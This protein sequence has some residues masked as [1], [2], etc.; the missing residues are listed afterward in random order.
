MFT[1]SVVTCIV[2]G[3]LVSVI[4]PGS[5]LLHAAH[6]QKVPVRK[7]AQ[8]PR[9]VASG[10]IGAPI[11]PAE[12]KTAAAEQPPPHRTE[13][14]HHPLPS[15]RH[16]N[17]R[18]GALKRLGTFTVRAYTQ[19]RRPPSKTASGTH[20]T[21]GRTVAVDP[22]VIPLGS[23]IHIEGVG[24][25]IAEDTGGKIKG[26][27]LDLFLPSVEKCIDFG[28]RTLDVYVLTE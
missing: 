8:S 24:E 27:R 13:A 17:T 23:K 5:S 25:W 7:A 16:G 18:Q 6:A 4:L 10:T 1:K 26:K 11:R 19:Y 12:Q 15:G 21:V 3:A 9:G 20:P 14:R 2:S 28:K 22:R